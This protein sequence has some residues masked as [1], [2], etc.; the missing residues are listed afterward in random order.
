MRGRSDSPLRVLVVDDN[1]DTAG[2]FAM[3]LKMWGHEVKTTHDGPSALEA[4]REFRPDAV[5]LDIGLPR[6]D[7][8]EVAAQLRSHPESGRVLIVGSSG[9]SRDSDYRRAAEVGIDKYFIKP[10]DPWQLESI[11][12]AH[13]ASLDAIPA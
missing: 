8:F 6:M 4:A 2:I 7:G 9:Y 10:F 12:E 1:A 5:L 13:R 11:L 3:L